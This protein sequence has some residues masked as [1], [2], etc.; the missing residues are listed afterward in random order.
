[1]TSL[2]GYLAP[3]PSE[4][5]MVQLLTPEGE[6]VSHPDYTFTGTDHQVLGL[7]RDMALVR[8]LDQ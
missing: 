7:Y 3:T 5:E 4:A 8:R 2:D 6:R 1:M